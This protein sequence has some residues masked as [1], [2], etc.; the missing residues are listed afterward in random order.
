MKARNL[1]CLLAA[2]A[3]L[4]AAAGADES[5]QV[6]GASVV[7]R[8]HKNWDLLNSRSE[9]WLLA[10]EEPEPFETVTLEV[11]EE[12]GV[13]DFPALP[14]ARPGKTVVV[15]LPEDQSD[16]IIRQVLGESILANVY[17]PGLTFMLRDNGARA[18]QRRMEIVDATG[19]PMAGATVEVYLSDY[20]NPTKVRVRS[21]VLDAKGS[22]PAVR[23]ENRYITGITL[24]VSDPNYGAAMVQHAQNC[25]SGD[26]FTVP[27]VKAGSEAYEYSFHGVAVD[28]DGRPV[29]GV[30]LA[31]TYAIAAGG[32]NV[33]LVGSL[34]TY[35]LT[36]TEGRFLF[37]RRLDKNKTELSELPA[38]AKYV[39]SVQP[40]EGLCLMPCD[41]R[42]SPGE[43]ARVVLE[44]PDVYLRRFSF[45]DANGVVG[46]PNVLEQVCVLIERQG[47]PTLRV[48]YHL[49]KDGIALP[50][51]TYKVD[52]Y[53]V[54]IPE[55]EPIEVTAESPE[56]LVFRPKSTTAIVYSG[57]V[58]NGITGEP[59]AGAF[60][61]VGGLVDKRA[62]MAEHWQRLESLGAV[63]A[64]F[65]NS[66]RLIL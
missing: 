17:S 36:D 32:T 24:V 12:S 64:H 66:P 6:K 27:L 14:D 20:R 61:G 13:L 28:P 23:M 21:V 4:G 57:R 37:Y 11:K 31:S 41:L 49:L 39:V 8:L 18:A 29:P 58:V 55:F 56:Q 47:K 48:I 43:E 9:N 16:P 53:G 2:V 50:L 7:V 62:L 5:A 40:P 34:T 33:G 52:P 54:T 42:I 35:S 3:G 10:L 38:T 30:L 63:T 15:I 25:C 51:G 65:S 22:M 44:R 46:E 45:E 1:L 60:V 59:M 19:Q 26:V